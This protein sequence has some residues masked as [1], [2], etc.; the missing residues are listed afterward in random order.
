MPTK[1]RTESNQGFQRNNQLRT[2]KSKNKELRIIQLQ[3]RT[4][5][6]NCHVCQFCYVKFLFSLQ[7]LPYWVIRFTHITC[8][9]P[10]S[11]TP[12]PIALLSIQFPCFL[13][14]FARSSLLFLAQTPS[15]KSQLL[16]SRQVWSGQVT[17][18]KTSFNSLVGMRLQKAS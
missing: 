13:M 18:S 1:N 12:S 2:Q 17:E 16:M 11:C 10:L 9:F 14:H 5:S 3:K 8:A 7:I 4:E 15:L 6:Q